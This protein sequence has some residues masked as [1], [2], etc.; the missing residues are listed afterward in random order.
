MY[1]CERKGNEDEEEGAEEDE[2]FLNAR[3]EYRIS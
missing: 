1:L 3:L 2:V